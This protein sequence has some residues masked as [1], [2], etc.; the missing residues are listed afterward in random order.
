MAR[1]PI[2][3]DSRIRLEADGRAYEAE[4]GAFTPALI[5]G[6]EAKQ[7][8]DS[9]LA[10]ECLNSLLMGP[11]IQKHLRESDTTA[12]RVAP[13]LR[14]EE[15]D[16]TSE[17]CAMVYDKDDASQE[18]TKPRAQS[19][20]TIDGF[21]GAANTKEYHVRGKLLR[22]V[23]EQEGRPLNDTNDSAEV[24]EAV[25]QWIDAL[26][27]L[28]KVRVF[29]QGISSGNLL[30]KLDRSEEGGQATIIDVGLAHLKPRSGDYKLYDQPQEALECPATTREGKTADGNRSEGPHHH[31]TL[32]VTVSSVER[33]SHAIHHD[34]ESIF[35][36]VVYSCMRLGGNTVQLWAKRVVANLCSKEVDTMPFHAPVCSGHDKL[37]LPSASF[38]A[39]RPKAIR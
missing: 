16:Y 14:T 33:I 17:Y 23:F 6:D 30:P 24:L 25:T 27:T 36:V 5:S 26:I 2:S 11:A 28:D 19:S 21:H 37:K 12:P 10:D 31:V 38:Q 39:G 15:C 22:F 32:R 4:A 7:I 35:W 18:E 34:V 29:H 9:R 20:S 13:T 1:V 3:T 8:R